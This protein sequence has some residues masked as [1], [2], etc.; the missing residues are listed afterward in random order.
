MKENSNISSTQLA[1]DAHMHTQ[2]N[3][4]KGYSLFREKEEEEE[5]KRWREVEEYMR[6]R[7]VHV[8]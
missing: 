3:H 7:G 6:E 8:E 1:G 5:E 4:T 2:T